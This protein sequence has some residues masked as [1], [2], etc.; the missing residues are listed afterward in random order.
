MGRSV[1]P[2]GARQFS[3]PC[4]PE[5]ARFG[6]SSLLGPIARRLTRLLSISIQRLLGKAFTVDLGSARAVAVLVDVSGF[7]ARTRAQPL[8]PIGICEE[9]KA[10]PR[11]DL[12]R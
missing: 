2:C 10:V 1:C 7:V 8:S 3:P 5:T 12:T 9:R 6:G 11:A 4:T